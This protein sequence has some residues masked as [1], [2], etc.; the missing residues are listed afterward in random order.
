[1]IRLLFIDDDPK[2]QKMLKMV[3]GAQY[4]VHSAFTAKSGL[5]L[6]EEADPEVVLLDINLP[7]LDG[8][9]VLKDIVARP[10]APP[11]VMLTSYPDVDFV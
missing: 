8:L 9:E 5:D 6:L 4:H 10:G 1:M 7:D 3:L 2:A 11:V